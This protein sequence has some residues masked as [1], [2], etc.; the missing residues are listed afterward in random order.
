MITGAAVGVLGMRHS[1]CRWTRTS[2]DV[3]D[4]QSTSTRRGYV[5]TRFR[6]YGG[7]RRIIAHAEDRIE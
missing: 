2:Q 7:T 1:R 5:P 4:P 6:S 3:G